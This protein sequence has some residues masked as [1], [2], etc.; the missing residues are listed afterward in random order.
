M[1][2]EELLAKTQECR[3]EMHRIVDAKFDLIVDSIRAGKPYTRQNTVL[4]LSTAPSR[5][6]GS[7]PKVV[8]FAD[9]RRLEVTKWRSAVTAI[10]QE[11]VNTMPYGDRLMAIRGK[12]LGR[13]RTILGDSPQGMNVPL[14]IVPG[15]YMEGKFDTE[16]LLY[17]LTKRI[18]DPVGYDYG[19]IRI[20]LRQQ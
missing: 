7:K 5:F 15:L 8:I 12:I 17:V 1:T 3:A 20:Q 4:S 11:C 16:A 10:L 19:G 6:K 14:E 18:L 2:T 9:E 13:Q